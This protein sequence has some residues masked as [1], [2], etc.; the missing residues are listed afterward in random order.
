MLVLP[1][2]IQTGQLIESSLRLYAG[3]AILYSEIHSEQDVI[4]LQR[5]RHHHSV[6]RK[7]KHG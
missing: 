4:R 6:G 5:F 3:D 2:L 7:L 1:A